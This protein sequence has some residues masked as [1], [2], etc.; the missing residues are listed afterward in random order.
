[1]PPHF[2]LSYS[3]QTMP[4]CPLSRRK[5]GFMAAP[6]PSFCTSEVGQR[7]RVEVAPFHQRGMDFSGLRPSTSSTSAP[8]AG[9]SA[10]GGFSTFFGRGGG[11][12]GGDS[13]G[14]R[15]LIH[16]AARRDFPSPFGLSLSK[17]CPSFGLPY[18]EEG[19][20]LDVARHER[21]WGL[22][23]PL[24]LFRHAELGSA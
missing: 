17:P 24:P 16:A 11:V 10:R 14:E 21:G 22:V 20:C 19:R 1:M 9:R 13:V 8:F 18:P 6:A 5:G 3:P 12:F 4:H 7:G 2:P 23:P 15:A